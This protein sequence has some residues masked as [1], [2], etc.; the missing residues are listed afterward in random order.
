MNQTK[1]H[2][3]EQPTAQKNQPPEEF[4]PLSRTQ[5]T[6]STSAT[7]PR[8]SYAATAAKT[9]TKNLYKIPSNPLHQ[10][11]DNS[12]HFFR[13]INPGAVVFFFLYGSFISI[14]LALWR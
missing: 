13:S 5:A 2:G 4:P 7:P 3:H 9:I 12:G 8:L 14:V 1:V 11:T 6:P 10:T